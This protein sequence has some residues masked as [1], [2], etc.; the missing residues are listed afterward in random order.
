[1]EETRRGSDKGKITHGWGWSGEAASISAA[2]KQMQVARG[3]ER[4]GAHRSRKEMRLH[5][6]TAENSLCTAGCRI[7]RWPP[8]IFFFFLVLQLSLKLAIEKK[9][10]LLWVFFT[11]APQRQ[12]TWLF[13]R[14]PHSFRKAVHSKQHIPFCPAL[15]YLLLAF[16]LVEGMMQ[17]GKRFLYYFLAYTQISTMQ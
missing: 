2:S 17:L 6:T 3:E 13:I 4:S 15:H 12:K 5:T 7:A 16:L 14:A 10:R 1:M 8:G 11:F 9:Q